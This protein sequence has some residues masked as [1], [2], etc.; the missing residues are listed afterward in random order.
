MKIRPVE[1]EDL[2]ALRKIV[3]EPGIIRFM[4]LP[5]PVPIERLEMWYELSQKAHDP[6]IFVIEE[7]DKPVGCVSIKKDGATSVWISEKYQNQGYGKQCIAW[8]TDYARE[9][10]MERVWLGCIK[11]NE[12]ALGFFLTVGFKKIKEEDG[13]VLMEMEL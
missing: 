2:P 9:K 12:K 10:K 4:P 1:R 11:E 3:N 7:D 13:L 5:D 8:L 6:E